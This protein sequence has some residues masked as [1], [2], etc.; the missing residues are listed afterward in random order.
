MAVTELVLEAVA[1]MMWWCKVGVTGN[2][3]CQE[4]VQLLI[5]YIQFEIFAAVSIHIIM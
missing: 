1:V 4:A 5:C 3:C 2:R